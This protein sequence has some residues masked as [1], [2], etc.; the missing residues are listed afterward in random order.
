[1]FSSF[2]VRESELPNLHGQ[3]CDGM[4]DIVTWSLSAVVSIDQSRFRLY[5]CVRVNSC[6]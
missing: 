5:R 1:M 4:L 3:R 2:I 6:T